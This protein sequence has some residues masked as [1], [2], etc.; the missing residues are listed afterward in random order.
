MTGRNAW[1]TLPVTIPL[2][3]E[4]K[5]EIANRTRDGDGRKLGSIRTPVVAEVHFADNLPDLTHGQYPCYH[6]VCGVKRACE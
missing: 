6:R 1:R 2:I 3:M 4:W 5:A